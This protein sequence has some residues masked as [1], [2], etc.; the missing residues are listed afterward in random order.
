MLRGE[1]V[2]DPPSRGSGVRRTV[3]RLG[4]GAV[5]ALAGTTHLTVAR[6]E[7][8]AQVPTWFPADPDAVVLA[9]GVV[10]IALGAALLAAPGRR[11]A[12]VGW[13]AAGFFVAIFPGNISQLVTRT[14]AFG[15]ES[16]TARAVRLVGQ[17][18]LVLWALWS[19][20][21]WRSLRAARAA[22]TW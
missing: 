12:A 5:L 7:F 2:A 8:Q 19:T 4:L 18:L 3:G 1:V 15:L 16:D 20:G 14:D 13:L 6:E 17:P 21:A 9:S 10:E 22:R 11:R